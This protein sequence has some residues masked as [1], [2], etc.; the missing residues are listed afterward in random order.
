MMRL[1]RMVS[2]SIEFWTTNTARLKYAALG[3]CMILQDIRETGT[4]VTSG[5]L[6]R[7]RAKM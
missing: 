2:A 3:R 6:T 4:I 5:H 7:T 1:Y